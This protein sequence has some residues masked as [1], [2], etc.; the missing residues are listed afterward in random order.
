[1]TIGLELPQPNEF[2]HGDEVTVNGGVHRVT[3]SWTEDGMNVVALSDRGGHPHLK[4]R[5]MPGTDRALL[6]L[7]VGGD[8]DAEY[9]VEQFVWGAVDC[10]D[11]PEVPDQDRVRL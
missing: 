5:W 11:Y 6:Q 9:P 3:G 4:L 10:Y 8:V 7:I 2:E 1:M